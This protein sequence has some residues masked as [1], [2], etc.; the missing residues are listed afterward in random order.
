VFL[1]SIFSIVFAILIFEREKRS[2]NRLLY[3]KSIAVC[4]SA[5][6]CRIFNVESATIIGLIFLTFIGLVSLI[7]V[8]TENDKIY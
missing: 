1:L 3:L 4:M 7:L 8:R 2:I 6:L 5:L